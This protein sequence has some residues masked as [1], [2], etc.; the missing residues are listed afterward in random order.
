VVSNR[1]YEFRAV[2]DAFGVRRHSVAE[3]L[4]WSIVLHGAMVPIATE[5]AATRLRIRVLGEFGRENLDGYFRT[6]RV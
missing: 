3:L 4:E 2:D 1:V 5:R 6:S